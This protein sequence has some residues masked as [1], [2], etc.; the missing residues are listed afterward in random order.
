VGKGE[1]LG[2]GDRHLRRGVEM[3][4][5][6][7]RPRHRRESEVLHDDRIDSAR[8]EVSQLL[9]RVFEFGREDERVKGNKSPHPVAMEESHQLG[10]ILV[11]EVVRPNPRVE[12]GHAEVN[13]IGPVRHGGA[14]ALP[15]AGGCEE[16][17]GGFRHRRR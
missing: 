10:Q 3:E 17:G 15:V 4:I 8:T 16:F 9:R 5:G 11:R 1:R 7:H 12:A 14:G 13:R 6:H 2:R